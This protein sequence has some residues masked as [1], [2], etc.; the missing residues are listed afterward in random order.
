[1]NEQL[2]QLADLYAEMEKAYNQVSV[3]LDFT[4]A[5]CPDNCCDSHF[6][7][8]T[9]IEWA[10]LWVGFGALP[11]EQQERYLKRAKEYITH[12]EEALAKDSR[13]TAMC[14]LNDNGRCALYTHRMMICRLHGVPASLTSPNGMKHQF[15]GCFRCQE[16][17]ADKKNTTAMDRTLFFQ[18][19][20]MLE[21][22]FV[23]PRVAQ[24]PKVKLTLAQML[25]KG[26]PPFQPE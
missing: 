2:S 4:C 8:H 15:P 11:Q 6:L 19:M 12:S 13:P 26:P 25:V 21:R 17:N 7:H 1:M 20:V 3:L 24:L 18:K 10:Y 22:S 23:G 5:D 16:L 9:Y 14:P